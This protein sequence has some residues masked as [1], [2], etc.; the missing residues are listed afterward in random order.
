[1]LLENPSSLDAEIFLPALR[2]YCGAVELIGG[3]EGKALLFSFPEHESVYEDGNK[4]L[5]QVALLS[6]PEPIEKDLLA[7]VVQQSWLWPEC[8]SIASKHS[9]VLFVTDLFASLL[10]RKARLAL[11]KN[12]IRAILEVVPS[13]AVNW[14]PSQQLISPDMFLEKDNIEIDLLFPAVNVRMFKVS[15]GGTTELVMD[16]LGLEIFG[17]PDFQCRYRGLEPREVAAALYDAAYY[18]FDQGDVIKDGET[19][20]GPE[21]DQR[22]V[23][24]EA[25]ALAAPERRVFGVD[26]LPVAT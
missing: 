8:E 11:F 10:D 7:S 13:L 1:L 12:I 16:T 14:I 24:R 26:I 25:P 19:I 18:V 23:C 15:A 17:L 3:E 21:A 20:H 4:M 5:A 2:K 6:K 22:W 9:S